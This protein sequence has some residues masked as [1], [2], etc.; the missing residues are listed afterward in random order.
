MKITI[1]GSIKFIKEMMETKQKLVE[2]GH[3]VL[4]PLSAEINQSKEYWINLKLNDFNRFLVL[5]GERMLGHFD[6]IKSSDAIIVLN[7]DKDGIKNYV[8]GATFG[9]IMVAFHYNKKIFLLNPI[10]TDERLAFIIDE[11]ESVKPIVIN[12]NLDLIK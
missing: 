7:Y 6:K 12:G 9:E 4:V 1:C 10:P 5:R 3:D 2:L 8:G 11:I